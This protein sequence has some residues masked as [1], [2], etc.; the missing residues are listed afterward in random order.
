MT[1]GFSSL[2]IIFGLLMSGGVSQ[3]YPT[4]P[5]AL[6]GRTI[7]GA[8]VASNDPSAVM[9]YDP[10]L[11][12]TWL[13]DWN[14]AGSGTWQAMADWA[15]SL[16]VGA[17][18]NWSLPSALNEDGSGP[19]Y[20][21]CTS[22]QQGYLWSVELGNLGSLTNVGPFQNVQPYMYY[23]TNTELAPGSPFA[24]NFYMPE[25]KMGTTSKEFWSYAAAVRQ[26]DVSTPVPEPESWAFLLVGLGVLTVLRRNS[27]V[28]GSF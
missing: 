1:T 10:N 23:W 3:A 21:I 12:I 7:T 24:W 4:S 9:E 25:G 2:A 11:N 27:S 18:G 28:E 6:Q 14:A 8:A 15:A 5:A 16:Q 13:R 17:F 26:G 22:T 20:G 19:C